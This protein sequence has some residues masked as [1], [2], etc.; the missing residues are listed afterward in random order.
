MLLELLKEVIYMYYNTYNI[1]DFP[2][3][4]FNE[5]APAARFPS[6]FAVPLL[7]QE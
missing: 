7:G 4:P 3:L 5:E 6:P 1:F 2:L